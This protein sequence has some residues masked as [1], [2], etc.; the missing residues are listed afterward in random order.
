V[1][2]AAEKVVELYRRDEA[3]GVRAAALT[4]MA[5]LKSPEAFDSLKAA[6]EVDAPRSMLRN[7]ALRGFGTLGDERAVPVVLE[8]T[9]LGRP[10]GSRAAAIASLARL[11]LANR[12]VE[13]QLIG[14]VSEPYPGVRAAALRSLGLRGDPSAIAPLEA[15]LH[16]GAFGGDDEA[17]ASSI[18][19][20]LK[21]GSRPSG[22]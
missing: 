15:L 13:S 7:A 4:A 16:N 10:L 12:E 5:Q 20:R 3:F 11:S 14:Y 19:Q 2:S 22:N 8:W 17:L 9:Q 1:P 18:V 21:M 6:V